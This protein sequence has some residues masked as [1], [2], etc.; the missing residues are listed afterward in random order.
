MLY[1]HGE[2]REVLMLLRLG[3]LTGEQSNYSQ[4]ITKRSS[5]IAQFM[6]ALRIDFSI[7]GL[8]TE[9][10]LISQRTPTPY[11]HQVNICKFIDLVMRIQL[12][13]AILIS[14]FSNFLRNSTIHF[15]MFSYLVT[16]YPYLISEG[17]PNCSTFWPMQQRNC[18][19]QE[20][21]RETKLFYILTDTATKLWHSG[22]MTPNMKT[23]ESWWLNFSENFRIV[24]SKF[25]ESSRYLSPDLSI[26]C[27]LLYICMVL[28]GPLWCWHL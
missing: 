25:L 27:Y 9:N 21:V 20:T 22:N 4:I 23:C 1:W 12:T 2:D 16:F 7:N 28:V 24:A 11:K 19:T 17:R 5:L 3:A 8:S 6:I 14:R 18:D 10:R 26:Y 15:P 13:L